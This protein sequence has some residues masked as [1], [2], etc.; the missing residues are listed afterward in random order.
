MLIGRR[1]SGRYKIIRVIGGGGMANVYLA[2]DIILER[3]VAV[4]VLRLDFAHE[5]EF[6]R[7]FQREA[8]AA[9]SLTH[10]NIVS[11]YDIGEDGDISYIVMEYVDGMTLKQFIQ[12]N[13]PVPIEKTLD[14]MRQLTSAVAHAHQNH[15]VHRDIKPQ[16]ILIDRQGHVMIT[17]FGIAMALS[18]TSIT[19]TN[20][21]LGSVHYLSPE[22]AR[23]GMATKKSDIYS[24]GIVMFELLTGRLPFSGESAI[25][26]A[27]KHL[28][29]DTPSPSRWNP[30]IPQS[31]ENIVLKAT[32]KDPFLRYANAE[33]MERQLGTALN[34]ERINEP[35]F[36]IPE[37]V[38]ATKAIPVITDDHPYHHN[39][40]TMPHGKKQEK[41]IE[42]KEIQKKRR[43]KWPWVVGSL[44][45]LILLFVIAYTFV[46]PAIMKAQTVKIPDLSGEEYDAAILKLMEL[47]LTVGEKI[48]SPS[49]EIPEGA[50]IKTKPGA[51]GEVKKGYEIDLYIS[52]GKERFPLGDYRGR[53]IDEIKRLI[54]DDFQDIDIQS[55]YDESAEGTILE[56]D[57]DPNENV[58]PEETILTFVVSLGEEK[59]SLKDLS[60]Y[61]KK[62]LEDYEESTGF[63][64]VES[65]EYNDEIAIGH[66][67]RQDPAP[68]TPLVK[69]SRVNVVISK[70]PQPIPPK[71]V[72]IPIEIP[73]E[74]EEEGKP[75]VVKVFIQDFNHKDLNVPADTF[76]IEGPVTRQ[77][78]LMVEK[79]QPAGYRVIRDNKVIIEEDVAFPEGEE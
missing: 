39:G 63:Q 1:I 69:G 51:D 54:G 4:K 60:E 30:E 3:E 15:I 49:D 55:V 23:G 67:I 17:D 37:D 75:Q 52:T 72:T 44:I 45:T 77:I 38:D 29:S 50:V 25:S 73:Y 46:V 71:P 59:I 9:T 27:L 26:I 32:A 56:Q 62:G 47:G 24:I 70:G 8:Q 65:E 53:H 64:I 33:E 16:N 5:E 10:E 48:P 58:I 31:V 68:N 43:K 14:I 42:P 66:V 41:E 12:Q 36:S 13:H 57:P 21:V 2:H 6:I 79:G 7:R 18:A 20:A 78:V 40:N 76:E 11:I 61:N 35:K 19:Q 22:Q 28:Q 34:P 74:P